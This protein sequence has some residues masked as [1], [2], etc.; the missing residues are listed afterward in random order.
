MDSPIGPG[1]EWFQG[2]MVSRAERP[3]RRTAS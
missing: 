1:D 3:A 2:P